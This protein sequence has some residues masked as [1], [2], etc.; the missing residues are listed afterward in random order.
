MST[1][2]ID[3]YDSEYKTHRFDAFYSELFRLLQHGMVVKNIKI[4]LLSGD[5]FDVYYPYE[6]GKNYLIDMNLKSRFQNI[7]INKKEKT[8][9]FFKLVDEK[10]G[11]IGNNMK[12]SDVL[13]KGVDI[14]Q[15][16]V[17][18]YY[19]FNRTQK[20]LTHDKFISHCINSC[21]DYDSN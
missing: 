14:T 2:I 20:I 13:P 1:F 19:L 3:H 18:Y 8:L 12:I 17:E 15:H 9:F 10:Y 6:T 16:T 11:N 4:K 7:Q 21:G 5:K